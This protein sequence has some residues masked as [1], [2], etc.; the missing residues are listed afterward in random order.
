[1]DVGFCGFDLRGEVCDGCGGGA[2]EEEGGCEV[3]G[4]VVG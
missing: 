1:M 2:E 4:G 3:V